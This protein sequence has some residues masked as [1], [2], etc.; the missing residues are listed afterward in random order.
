MF[1]SV[2]QITVQTIVRLTDALGG[3]LLL[4][5]ATLAMSPLPSRR[6]SFLLS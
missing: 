3:R 5:R 2:V 4:V 6:P 1:K